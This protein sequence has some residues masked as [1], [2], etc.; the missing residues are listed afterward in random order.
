MFSR[1]FPPSVESITE[2]QT[3]SNFEPVPRLSKGS[4][5][6]S[7]SRWNSKFQNNDT[8]IDEAS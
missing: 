4:D 8:N 7:F 1:G 2:H 5:T 6:V 3:I